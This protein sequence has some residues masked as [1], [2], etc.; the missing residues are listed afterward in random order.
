MAK[1]R[2]R[3]MGQSRFYSGGISDSGSGIEVQSSKLV[4]QDGQAPQ[5]KEGC[6]ISSCLGWCPKCPMMLCNGC[7]S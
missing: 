6:A 2:R 1:S 4:P 7:A 3:Q 5:H